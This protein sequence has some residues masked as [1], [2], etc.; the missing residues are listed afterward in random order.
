MLKWY[1]RKTERRHKLMTGKEII[2]LIKDTKELYIREITH[3]RE[4]LNRESEN[5]TAQQI[6][7]EVIF[8]QDMESRAYAFSLLL[9]EIEDR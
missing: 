2:T 5:M 9:E 3:A 8:I 7:K 6:A 4:R 1:R